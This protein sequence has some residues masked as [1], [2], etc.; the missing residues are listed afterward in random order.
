MCSTYSLHCGLTLFYVYVMLVQFVCGRR[1]KVEVA[2]LYSQNSAV[3]ARA[4]WS[5]VSFSTM[6][7]RQG[8]IM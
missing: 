6:V 2:T 7:E 5:S 8:A 1:L 4:K 3:T